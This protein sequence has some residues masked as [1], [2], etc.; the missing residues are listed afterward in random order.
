[1]LITGG[2][3]ALGYNLTLQLESLGGYDI[4]IIDN[5]SAGIANFSKN[6][7]FTN[8]DISNTEKV[9]SFF[10]KYKPNVIYHLA[11]HFAN[12]NSVDH[13]I[14]DVSTNV[15]GM[16]NLFEEQK[17]NTELEKI[18]YA[19]SSC[20][21]GNNPVMSEDVNITPY[22]TP[23]AINK[24]A[25]E[26]YAKYY[27]EIH[28]LPVACLR[29]FNSYGPGE[30]P[31]AYRNVI[32]NFIQKALRGENIYITGTGDETRDFTFVSDT[33][34]LLIKLAQA[35]YKNA[36]IFNGGTGSKVS[37]KQ[38]AELIIELS[39]SDSQIIYTQ[40]RNWDHV[41]NR[42]SDTSK[43]RGLLGYNPQGEIREGL[44]KTIQWIRE[45]LQM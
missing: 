44:E 38:L 29:I 33:V 45:K 41:K 28:K 15:I 4:H 25:G 12:Q 7:A 8:M 11:A 24:Y 16:I 36:E 35:E 39:G 23:Y 2:F 27:A 21:Y 9:K 26:L 22:D 32:P 1:M 42:C 34:E 14:S 13:P 31:G 30:M 20:V 40:P 43:S 3:G 10:D 6:V 37:I 19:S 17:N 18:V 5:L